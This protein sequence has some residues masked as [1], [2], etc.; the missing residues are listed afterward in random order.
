MPLHSPYPS[1][2]KI[3]KRNKRIRLAIHHIPVATTRKLSITRDA[4]LKFFYFKTIVIVIATR[5]CNNNRWNGRQDGNFLRYS[6]RA[7]SGSA[8]LARAT[9]A[10]S[11]VHLSYLRVH[12]SLVVSHNSSGAV[13]K[14]YPTTRLHS[15]ACSYA[16]FTLRKSRTRGEKSE[17]G[18]EGGLRGAK[19]ER[20]RFAFLR[21]LSFLIRIAGRV[22]AVRSGYSR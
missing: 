16:F 10:R 20:A 3:T 15:T 18:A 13:A 4:D 6:R 7:C 1:S 2:I 14:P 11:R 9:T 5:R 8:L 17:G 22:G 12:L 19:A 21:V